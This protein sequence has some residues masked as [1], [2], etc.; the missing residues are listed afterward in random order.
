M[1]RREFITLVGGARAGRPAR[2]QH[3]A[4]P[5]IGFL[6]GYPAESFT[7]EIQPYMAA[8]RPSA[9]QRNCISPMTSHQV[10]TTI[11]LKPEADKTLLP[12]AA[13]LKNEERPSR[14]EQRILSKTKNNYLTGKAPYSLHARPYA[15]QRG[16]HTVHRPSE[17]RDL[18]GKLISG[19]VAGQQD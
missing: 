2:A 7:P 18:S 19:A 5:V 11:L 4:M 17:A 15:D 16:A 14:S 3:A 1:R 6:S 13:R 10:L 9:E 12:P 8:F